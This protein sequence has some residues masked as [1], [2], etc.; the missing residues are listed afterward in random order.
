MLLNLINNYSKIIN[1]NISTEDSFPKDLIIDYLL[2]NLNNSKSSI[3][4]NCREVIIKVFE[5]FGPE[6]FKDKLS[7]LSEKEH[8]KLFK[9]KALQPMIN[10][11][12]N[13][14]FENLNNSPKNSINNSPIKNKGIKKENICSLCRLPLGEEKL[15]EHMKQYALCCRC[16]KCKI[17]VEVKN[18]VYHKLNECKYKNEYKVC[19][20]CKEAIHIKSYKIHTQ[21]KKCNPYKGNYLRCPLC[22]KD[23]PCSNKGFFH[24]LM[25]NGC[26]VR[27]QINNTYEAGV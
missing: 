19:P 13:T 14:S 5:L 2:I 4:D 26:P 25:N 11:I 17:F 24:H 21:N 6:P 12:S 15:T 23:I 1:D 8:E 20:R 10:S 18:L 7:C 16:K 9:I 3:K 27:A 22:H